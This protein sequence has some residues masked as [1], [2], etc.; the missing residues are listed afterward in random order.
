MKQLIVLYIIMNI[1]MPK[2]KLDQD[3]L[4]YGGRSSNQRMENISFDQ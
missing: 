2:D 4:L 3:T 1:S